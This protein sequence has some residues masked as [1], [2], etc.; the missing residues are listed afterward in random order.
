MLSSV[1]HAQRPV[2]CSDAAGVLYD[3]TCE[4]PTSFSDEHARCQGLRPEV[5]GKCYLLQIPRK[6]H[7][8]AESAE[9]RSRRRAGSGAHVQL[10]HEMSG[11]QSGS[12]QVSAKHLTGALLVQ[13]SAGVQ[14]C[15]APAVGEAFPARLY[16]P[17]L[18]APISDG[19]VV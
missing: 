12:F 9:S 10:R 18:R 14:T 8:R 6:I 7:S 5:A 16:L 1:W 11:I 13:Y 19:T 17:L 4:G 15:C 3:G 2:W